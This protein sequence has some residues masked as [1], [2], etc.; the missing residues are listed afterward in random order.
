MDIT[1][2]SSEIIKMINKQYI[3]YID[4]DCLDLIQI[5]NICNLYNENKNKKQAE[6]LK[7]EE[8][9]KKYSCFIRIIHA[10]LKISIDIFDINDNILTL[11]NNYQLLKTLEQKKKKILQDHIIMLR[12][13]YKNIWEN[14]SKDYEIY[15]NNFLVKIKIIDKLFNQINKLIDGEIF[16]KTDNLLS[17]ILPY[18]YTYT[19]YIEVYN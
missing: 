19:E 1:S 10:C 8:F 14:V 4:Q 16:S 2:M 9:T 6:I 7:S 13:Q 11:K 3:R 5:K 12:N 15:N 17:L 18:F